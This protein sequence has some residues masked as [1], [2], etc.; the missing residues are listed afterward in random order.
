ARRGEPEVDRAPRRI[1]ERAAGQEAV[2]RDGMEV[3][4]DFVPA[5]VAPGRRPLAHAADR[6]AVAS[7]AGEPRDPRRFEEKTLR[8]DDLVVVVPAQGAREARE[9]ATGARRKEP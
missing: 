9:L 3:A 7:P 4:R 1:A 2:A 5:I 6:I 8:I